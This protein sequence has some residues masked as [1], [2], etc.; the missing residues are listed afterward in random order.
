MFKNEAAEFVYYRTYSKWNPENKRRE[1]WPETVDRVLNFFKEERANLVPPKV[2]KKIQ[3]SMLTFD[4]LPSM[5][6]VWAAGEAA[7]KSNVTIYNC[8][9]IPVDSIEAFSECL[10]I[11][12]CG[13][14]V[15][16]SV[17]Q[18]YINKL[19]VIPKLDES[20]VPQT[21]IIGDSKEGWADSV[22]FLLQKLYD[23]K[24]L[25]FDYS[26]IRPKGSPLKTMGGRAS[27]PEP[28]IVLHSFIKE[29]FNKAQGRKLTT[30]ECH[31][32]F[33]KIAEIVVSGGVRRSS[34]ISLSDLTD[35]SMRVAKIWPFPQHRAM[36]NNSA[37]F[38]D[39]PSAV[40]FLKEWS[41]LASSGTGE[42]G[43][44]NL[45]ATRATAP[46]RRIAELID[47]FNP[48]VTG[49][50]LLLTKT[51]YQSIESLVDSE[52]TIWNGFEWSEVT[53]KI[54][55]ENQTILKIKFSDGRELKCT[56]YHK[57]HLAEGYTGNSIEI[58]AHQLKLGDKLIKHELP[59]LD[60]KKKANFN[61]YAQGFKS[62]EG[63]DDY[64]F[65]W[66]YEPKFM[67]SERL[68]N[69]KQ[70]KNNKIAV[71]CEVPYPK[72]YVPFDLGL[73]DQLNWL[74][75]LLDG[76]GCEL[77]EGG[78]QLSSID[79]TFLTNLQNLLAQLGTQSKIVPGM[80]GGY[81]KLPNG[82]G[83]YKAFWCQESKRIC[84]GAV[85]IQNLK[86]L[87][88][89]CERLL[90][91]KSPQR[92][93]SQ[94]CKIVSIEDM[95]VVEKVYCFNEPKRHLGL[96]NGI[97]TGQCHEIALRSFEFCNLSTVI[98]TPEDDLESLLEKVETATW[99]GAIQSTFTDFPYLRPIW[100][101]NCEEECLLGVSLSG[102]MDNPDILT[103]DALK[104]LKQRA[105]RVAKRAS[106]KL[107][108]NFAAA[109][110]CGKP[111]GTTSQLVASGSGA[112]TWYGPYYIRRYRIAGTDPLYKMMK[113][114]GFKFSPENGQT[115]ENASTWVVSFPVKAPATAKF[116]DELSAL[117]Q[118]EWYK[119]IQTN[120]CEHNQS[121]T[122]YVKDEEWF[123]VGNWVYKNWDICIGVSFLPYDGGKYEQ[124]PYEE[125]T[126]EQYEKMVAKFPKIDY[127]QL[128]Q[129]E[130]EDNTEGAKTFACV[131][132]RCELR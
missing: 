124:A 129:Y 55:G 49:D 26:S 7:R 27:G 96:F 66:L 51:G 60:S 105:L 5:R 71:K 100:K 9:F 126:K 6:M 15:G 64:N 56:P 17:E 92:D 84:I 38:Y 117:D 132:D 112:H 115:K 19:E 47:G 25:N 81:R 102:Q 113:D 83:S 109:V 36:A 46:K 98:V 69:T 68:G 128:S 12:C 93:A 73:E 11:L 14:G 48:C 58:E 78:A 87:G 121:V 50:T 97:I 63:M 20:L 104:A 108:V 1:T 110:T 91:E 118:L 88:L 119:R 80:P 106:E 107:G 74:A 2:F 72:S 4:V 33:N 131:G 30:L 16:F 62:A 44:S 13:T 57:F 111:E 77:K 99:I 130:L 70:L 123:D 76:D 61:A 24:T 114:Q 37:V 21:C 95:G 59:V 8:S 34:Q 32:I 18:K 120:W 86:D 29:V 23:G 90:F 3:E 22:K 31:D 35:E 125:I 10:Y 67:C 41:S 54:T 82:H 85:Q 94:F 53:P 122:V 103:P 42:R 116:R 127:S 43:I 39:K 28:L 75:G 65:L 89:K 79:F 101:Q 52:V 40:E 45:G